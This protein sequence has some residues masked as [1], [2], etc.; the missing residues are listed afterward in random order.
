MCKVDDLRTRNE[1]P[2]AVGRP[3]EFHAYADLVEIW[4][5]I[6]CHRGEA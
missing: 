3:V 6:W 4:S 1:K 5:D 2:R